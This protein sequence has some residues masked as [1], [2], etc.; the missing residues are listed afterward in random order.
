MSVSAVS[1]TTSTT[2][3][4]TASGSSAL[5][6]LSGNFNEF[7]T[8]LMTQL[9]NQDPTSPMDSNSFTQELV[10]FAGVQ[11]QIDTNTNL[12]SLIQLTQ[13]GDLINT[14]SIVGKNVQVSSSQ[15]SLQNGT[16]EIGFSAAAAETVDISVYN[17]AG[18]VIDSQ[19]VSA[20][21][22]SNTWTWDGSETSGATAPDGAY[23]IS[24]TTR[25]VSS[26]TSSSPSTSAVPFSV[27]GAAT[28][29]VESGGTL[30]LE[31]GSLAVPFSAV[32]SVSD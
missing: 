15:I 12:T 14:A 17:N 10:E 24:V 6:S 11:Q 23:T 5:D 7:L 19:T 8:M 31:L 26:S 1:G 27:I 32:Q 21:S 3:T 2:T 20:S 22:G 25:N 9:Q 28:G 16:G 30:E 13:S 18:S 29:V 4:S